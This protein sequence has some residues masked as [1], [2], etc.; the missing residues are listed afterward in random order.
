MPDTP[1][2]ERMRILADA[3][4]FRVWPPAVLKELAREAALRRPA[5]RSAV[6][7]PG[8]EQ[9]FVWIVVRGGI[10]VGAF[11]A[12]GKKLILHTGG[13]GYVYGLLGLTRQAPLSQ[14]LMVLDD[15]E[16]LVLS[17]ERLR[18]VLHA[19]PELWESIAAELAY[20]YRQTMAGITDQL[21]APLSLRL[22]L[23]LY[24]LA[25]SGAGRTLAGGGIAV[26]VSQAD[27]AATLGVT[28]QSVNREL[29]ALASQGVVSLSYGK[30][31][32]NDL[33]ALR[34]RVQNTNSLSGGRA[35]LPGPRRA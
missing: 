20:R 33:P 31:V 14:Y 34:Q 27:L 19:H 29:Q 11:C 2:A 10:E 4:P 1:L 6:F 23:S 25:R 17:T 21:T 8:D 15:A 13:P 35:V 22:S 5:S 7:R 28:R 16:L 9:S 26:H 18:A 30:V 3:R 32:V 24:A 12:D